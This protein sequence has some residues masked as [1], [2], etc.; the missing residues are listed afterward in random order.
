MAPLQKAAIEA[1]PVAGLADG[2]IEVL[3]EGAAHA[4]D[5]QEQGA[6][7]AAHQAR[8]G[9]RSHRQQGDR[10]RRDA[11][12]QGHPGAQG[13]RRDEHAVAHMNQPDRRRFGRLPGEPVGQREQPGAHLGRLAGGEVG[14]AA[15]LH[16]PA[17]RDHPDLGEPEHPGGQ[18]RHD[19][20]GLDASQRDAERLA[21]DQ[22]GLDAQVG[23]VDAPAGDRPGDDAGR[24]ADDQQRGVG[25]QRVA[26]PAVPARVGRLK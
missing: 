6:E 26:H 1:D 24:A 12:R 23:A 18:R 16:S 14:E 19:V 17:R 15:A 22:A 21:P 2:E 10:P 9:A 7:A 11:Q 5:P 8:A 13:Q 3:V 25:E 4:H 20:D